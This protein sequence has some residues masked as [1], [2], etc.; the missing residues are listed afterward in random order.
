MKNTKFIVN[1]KSKSYPVYFGNN[2]INT[3][4]KLVKKIYL[5]LKKYA[6]L[7]IKN[8]LTYY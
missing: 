7:V 1:T 2:I 4:G 8:Y 6:S 3:T 5:M